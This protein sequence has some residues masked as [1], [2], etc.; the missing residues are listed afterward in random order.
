[1]SKELEKLENMAK[2]KRITD[3]EQIERIVKNMLSLPFSFFQKDEARYRYLRDDFCK[4]FNLYQGY[5]NEISL[6]DVLVLI[7]YEPGNTYF[8]PPDAKKLYERFGRKFNAAGDSYVLALLI[9]G[10]SK[11]NIRIKEFTNIELLAYTDYL[12]EKVEDEY[13]N[14]LIPFSTCSDILQKI[15]AFKHKVCEYMGDNPRTGDGELANGITVGNLI[16]KALNTCGRSWICSVK[17]LEMYCSEIIVSYDLLN[18]LFMDSVRMPLIRKDRERF[19]EIIT[20]YR[21]YSMD[22]P[23]NIDYETCYEHGGIIKQ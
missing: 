6:E 15:E 4:G 17:P 3:H 8:N 23:V 10:L 7:G 18:R 9:N 21:D 20:Q 14:S 2:M 16:S 22:E 5:M 11:K 13:K 1:M 19:Q 12:R